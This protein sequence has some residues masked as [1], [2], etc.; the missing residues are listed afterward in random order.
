MDAITLDAIITELGARIESTEHLENTPV[1][2]E[3]FNGLVE[4]ARQVFPD[5]SYVQ[6]FS[7]VDHSATGAEPTDEA[8]KTLL[9]KLKMKLALLKAYVT[10]QVAK[11]KQKTHVY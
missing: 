1:L 5:E 9:E 11:E 8:M 4:E 2:V 3:E 7:T 6:K 10:T